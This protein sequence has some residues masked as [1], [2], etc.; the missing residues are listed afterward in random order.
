M[1]LGALGLAAADAEDS[2]SSDAEVPS[3]AQ[4][5]LTERV[6]VV[7]TRLADTDAKGA[8]IPAHVTVLE[9]DRLA[10]PGARTLQDVLSLE[11]GAIVYDQTGNDLEK[12]FDLRGFRSGSGTRVFL[13]GAPINDPRSNTLALELIP[14]EGLQRVTILRGSSGALGGGG[15]E[16]GV[17][18]LEPRRA[19]K[20][21]AGFSL[22]AGT[23]G[24][25]QWSGHGG[26]T[27]GRSDLYLAASQDENDG[28]R[29]NGG[30]E[31]RR[32][33]GTAGLDLGGQRRL[34][35]S[36]IASRSNLGNPGALTG[37]EWA[38][39]RRA[40]PYN[41]LDFSRG[42][43]GQ[44]TLNYRGELR[45]GLSVAANLFARSRDAALLTTGRA[46]SSFGGF[47]LDSEEATLGS[48]VQLTY[49]RVGV[50]GRHAS[51]FGAEWL[52]GETDSSGYFTS[53]SAL[54]DVDRDNPASQNTT[55]RRTQ[56]LFIQE[57][58]Q[59]TSRWTLAAG[60]R[61][62]RDRLSYD[63]A[64]PD[65]G[66]GDRRSFSELSVRA[67]VNYDP[68][69]AHGLWLAYG[70]SFLPPT[71]EDLFAFPLFGSN[72]DLRPEDARSLEL[73]YRHH[74][75]QGFGADVAL[76][77]IETEDEIVYDPDSPL[78]LFGANVNAGQTRRAGFEASLQGRLASRLE[79]HASLTLLDAEFRQGPQRGH[80]V[81][82]VPTERLAV[83]LKAELPHDL[84]LRVDALAVGEQRLDNDDANEQ[85]PL[86]AYVVV[87][88]RLGWTPAA[89]RR[90]ASSERGGATTLFIE[91]RNLLDREYATR[92][93]HAFNFAPE[94]L[95]P[96]TFFT[97][98][99]GRRW[100]TG[101]GWRY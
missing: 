53:P 61:W 26:T 89:W 85:P 101:V 24:T 68:H 72:P 67:G 1:L 41:D 22:A 82:L 98:A 28:F 73:G 55:Q 94:V 62:D 48:T 92:G 12:T 86:D 18:H 7:A 30:G 13:G 44:A 99:P 5:E 74:G 10:P 39:D 57:S 54:G 70:E 45:G 56:A 84:S 65:S 14:L 17:I 90:A 25:Q 76:F 35:L 63:E 97:P 49:R 100:L 58:W 69:A 96:D 23:H 88:A 60:A 2:V 75:A 11:A 3:P 79:A 78:G 34:E 46:A 9:G 93:I 66:V 51:S 16:A 80:E 8:P 38:E 43:L 87:H 31:L 4:S 32:L 95:G 59:P 77:V 21:T 37:E 27:F 64:L 47:F 40:S 50:S 36:V 33:M 83:G 15:S 71:P 42:H 52:D 19:D 20:P 81:P 91:V 6:R 29:I